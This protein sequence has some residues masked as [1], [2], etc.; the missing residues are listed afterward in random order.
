MQ[1][2]TLFLTQGAIIA[3]LYV[4][5][6]ELATLAGLSSG[7][8]QFRIS[9]ALCILS[10]FTPATIPALFIGCLIANLLAGGI[11]LDIVLGA[12]ASLLGAAGGYLLRKHWY[13]VPLPTVIAN[14]LIVPPVL[15]FAYGFEGALPYFML[16]VGVGEVVCAYVGGILLWFILKPYRKKLFPQ[17]L[18]D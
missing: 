10:A 6:T 17:S 16:T 13:L 5:L 15:K 14:I 8:I 2:K 1:K 11:P 7:V 9:E 4:A 12:V 3:A 18:T